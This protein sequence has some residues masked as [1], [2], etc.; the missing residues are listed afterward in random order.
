[1]KNI[2][3]IIIEVDMKNKK[4]KLPQLEINDIV[5][6]NT[7]EIIVK[8]INIIEPVRDKFIICFI[9]NYYEKLLKLGFDIPIIMDKMLNEMDNENAVFTGIPFKLQLVQETNNKFTMATLK[10]HI[11]ILAKHNFIKRLGN[12]YYAINPYYFAKGNMA[13]IA[14]LRLQYDNI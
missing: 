4:P 13:Y 5:N 14:K 11:H 2:F 12:N 1:M 6:R 9:S 3:F 10:N 7:G 8:D